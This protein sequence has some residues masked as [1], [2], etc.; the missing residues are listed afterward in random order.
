MYFGVSFLIAK[1]ALGVE[2]RDAKA[3]FC[4]GNKRSVGIAITVVVSR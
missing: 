1:G 2:R 4:L 3:A